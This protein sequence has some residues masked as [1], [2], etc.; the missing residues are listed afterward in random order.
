[1]ANTIEKDRVVRQSLD[2]SGGLELPGVPSIVVMKST[3]QELDG[4]QTAVMIRKPISK[5][6][7]SC[8]Q[9]VVECW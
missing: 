3:A 4:G 5:I 2:T 7:Y 9:D 1:M 8:G 6:P